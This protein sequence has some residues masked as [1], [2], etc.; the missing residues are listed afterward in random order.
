MGRNIVK[1]IL[2]WVFAFGL[3]FILLL[4]PRE[5]EMETGA[6][7]EFVAAHYTYSAD[8]HVENV[9]SFFIQLI[10]GEG[11]GTD[12]YDRPLLGHAWEMIQR[13]LWLIIPAFFVS[14]LLGI[15]KGVFDFQ[16]R[17]GKRRGAGLQT[18]WLGLSLPDLFFI[19]MIQ[20]TMM[21]LNVNGIVTG[22]KLYTHETIEAVVMN[23]IYLSIFPMFYLANITYAALSGEQGADYIRTARAKGVPAFKLLYIHMLR[24]GL[25]KI[26]VHTNTVVLYLLSNLFVI[27]YLTQYRGAA[28]YFKEYVAAS[29]RIVDGQ[30]LMVDVGA[31]VAFTL[32]F[33][34]MILFAGL[35]SQVARTFLLPHE[36][37]S[38]G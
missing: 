38:N 21:Y 11:L 36:R 4:L 17:H 2:Q 16:T 31:I 8:A 24:N 20:M 19:I 9:K 26:F 6:S 34:L 18:T 29:Q 23:V 25:A 14:I 37:G 10:N 13:S 12:R 33:T 27:E 1:L 28:Y 30:S 35:I 32:F 7:G 22:L 15:A 5:M 3:L